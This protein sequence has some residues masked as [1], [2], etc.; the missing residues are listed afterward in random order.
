MAYSYSSLS[1]YLQCERAYYH[2]YVAKD[3]TY[4]SNEAAEWGSACHDFLDKAI[5]G[6]TEVTPRFEF[7]APIVHKVRALDSK[8]ETEYPISFKDS[9]VPTDFK[10]KT[11]FIKGRLDCLIWHPT[12]PNRAKI[13]DWKIAKYKPENY[14]LEMEMF[15]LLTFKRHEEVNRIDTNLIWLKE[16]HAPTARTFTRE[17]LP[18]VEDNIM[19]KIERIENSVKEDK[20]PCRR[21]GLCYGFCSARNCENWQPAKKKY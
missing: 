21:S 10:D 17:G 5:R 20:W 19:S 15:S 7:L 13:L 9:W 8:V 18:E 14:V 16:I 1:K 11:A 6:E 12:D 2:T 4:T 3:A